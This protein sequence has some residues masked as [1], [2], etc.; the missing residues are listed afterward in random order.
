M[1]TR[2]WMPTSVLIA[3]GYFLDVYA[4]KE[5]VSGD[6]EPS[7]F[8]PT[9]I[10]MSRPVGAGTNRLVRVDITEF[11]RVILDDPS[12]NHGLVLGPLT[13]DKRGIFDVKNDAFGPGI[14]AQIHLVE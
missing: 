2:A 4:L 13:T 1:R 3:M 7:D 9:S 12:K 14:S 5:F 8:A 11:V 6:P 10:P